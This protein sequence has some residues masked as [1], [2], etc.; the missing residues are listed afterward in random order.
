M[1]KLKNIKIKWV[2]VGAILLLVAFGI[3][4]NPDRETAESFTPQQEAYLEKLEGEFQGTLAQNEKVKNI[5]L[6][7]VNALEAGDNSAFNSR[8]QQLLPEVQLLQDRLVDVRAQIAEGKSVFFDEEN[9]RKVFEVLDEI[10]QFRYEYNQ[11]V[12]ETAELGS[13]INFSNEQ[14]TDRLFV[15]LDDLD[16][17]ER[18]LPELSTKLID[19]L[20]AVNREQANYLS[21]Y[22]FLWK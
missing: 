2:I 7:V 12:I 5:T 1:E 8:S 9:I 4:N 20:G 14:Q 11:K 21:E 19:A 10:Y 17:R 15:L 16:E 22:P 6:E 13:T 18:Q 3:Y